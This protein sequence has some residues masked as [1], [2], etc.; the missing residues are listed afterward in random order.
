MRV[1]T[2]AA[3]VALATLVLAVQA[4]AA[5]QPTYAQQLAATGHELTT[6]LGELGA[7][8]GMSIRYPIKPSDARRAATRLAAVRSDL[9][10]IA[11]RLDAMHPPARARTPHARLAQAVSAL[12]VQVS[13]VLAKL[14]D[15][16]L[17]AAGELPNLP[18]ATRV[19]LALTALKKQGYRVG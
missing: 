17:V 9:Q 19:G 16:Y 11:K 14:R 15:G 12:A 7:V 5:A 18:A 10:A 3:A 4:T 6:S 13:P 8:A 1:V 2:G